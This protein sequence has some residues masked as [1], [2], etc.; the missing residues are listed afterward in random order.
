MIRPKPKPRKRPA[1]PP[2]RLAGTDG[3]ELAAAL[4]SARKAKGLVQMEL[5]G[6][7]VDRQQLDTLYGEFTEAI[8]AAQESAWPP[9][10]RR[11]AG[12]R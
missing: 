5:A 2:L 4:K 1:P 3:R 6:I 12:Q 8:E 10:P 11:P 7:E 9:W